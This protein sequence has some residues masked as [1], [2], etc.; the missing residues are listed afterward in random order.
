MLAVTDTE[1]A[2][3]RVDGLL[4][5]AVREDDLPTFFEHQQDSTAVA[6]AAV[7][8]REDDE[9]AT[10]WSKI[11]ADPNVITRTVVIEGQIAGN[12]VSWL[13]GSK[14]LVGYWIGRDYWGEG[15]ATACPGLL[16]R[17]GRRPSAVRACRGGERCVFPGVG[18]VRLHL[19]QEGAGRGCGRDHP[20][21]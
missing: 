11:L 9:F 10:H 6:M 18:E 17:R 8:A 1:G 15:V 3:H 14:R 13:H 4:L 2:R 20:P 16:R 5:R 7:A 12:V 19:R 21:T